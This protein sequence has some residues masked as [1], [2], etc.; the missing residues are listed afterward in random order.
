MVKNSHKEEREKKKEKQRTS[1]I[2]RLFQLY[3]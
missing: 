1:L 2:V 3:V